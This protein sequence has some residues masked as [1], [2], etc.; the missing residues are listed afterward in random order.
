MIEHAFCGDPAES[1]DFLRWWFE[2]AAGYVE[3]RPIPNRKDDREMAFKAVKARRSFATTDFEALRDYF[4]RGYQSTD[5][6]RCGWYFGVCLRDKPVQR[7]EDGRWSGGSAEDVVA[8]LGAWADIDDHDDE[9]AERM[10]QAERALAFLSE[11]GVVPSAVVKSGGGRGRHVYFKFT[12]SVDGTTGK[13]IAAKLAK[14]LGSDPN[15]ADAAR[16]M[17][18]PGSMHTKSGRIVKVSIESWHKEAHYN[19]EAFEAA[20]DEIAHAL[21]IDV[22]RTEP[23]LTPRE[24][25]ECMGDW[26]P[27]PAEFVEEQLPTICARFKA[28]VQ[29]PNIVSEPVWHKMASLLKAMNP[30]SSLFH[31]WSE[32]YDA[33]PGKRYNWGE[34]ERK[35]RSSRPLAVRCS[36]FQELDPM[37]V[38]AACRHFQRGSSPATFVRRAYAAQ[39]G[40]PG[41][42]GAPDQPEG[43]KMDGLPTQTTEEALYANEG[44]RIAAGAEDIDPREVIV[45]E[46][47][48]WTEDL[49]DALEEQ[50]DW[51]ER[52]FT[53][54]T[55]RQWAKARKKRFVYTDEEKGKEHLL[56]RPMATAIKED[57]NLQYFFQTCY[58]YDGSIYTTPTDDG[59]DEAVIRDFILEALETLK[60]TWATWSR[61]E[62]IKRMLINNVQ[63]DKNHSVE[64]IRVH[65]VWN[66]EP[67]VPFVNGLLDMSD[68][69][70]HDWRVY[71]FSPRH[72][73][74]WKLTIPFFE[75]WYRTPKSWTLAMKDAEVDVLD[76]FRTTFPDDET[77]RSILEFLGYCL[78]RW[79]QSEECYA[80]LYGPGQNGKSTLLGM[81]AKAFGIYAVTESVQSLERNRFASASLTRAAI[82]IV[83]DMAGTGIEDTSFLKGWIGNDV[84]RAE[85]KFKASFEFKPQTKLIY[86]ANELPPTKDPTHGYFRRILLYPMMERFKRQGPGWVE[87]LRTPEAL[88]YMCYLGLL[89][90]RQMRREGRNITESK[91]MLREKDYYWRANDVVKAAIDEGIIEFGKEFS[92]PRDLLQKAMEIYAK[93]TG[94]KYPGAA[95]LLE[96]LRNYA[97]HKIEYSRPRRNGKRIHMWTGVTLGEA[98]RSLFVSR[99][100][101]DL[102]RRTLEYITLPVTDAYAKERNLDN[103]EMLESGTLPKDDSQ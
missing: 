92:V 101:V 37:S 81:L 27:V 28:Y 25:V 26:K 95:K 54:E 47:I 34:A 76:F 40:L 24:N 68:P 19:P 39:L 84:V 55:A 49:S 33:G 21:G 45:N 9:D 36:T 16:V 18:I 99:E 100:I 73:I 1:V 66:T 62:E 96:R 86:G 17:R 42:Y 97:P 74:N 67:L 53:N 71:D 87:R 46:P 83:P 56:L 78:C 77:R 32:G 38:C 72:R 52:P 7:T 59:A 3:I 90:Y 82:D 2:G 79:D 22:S 65:E 10:D 41:L 29:D 4:G 51:S 103:V 102:D 11:R 43:P 60:P 6:A 31:K 12:C 48:A 70:D 15:V 35:F 63:R 94:R 89:H 44:T 85:R 50:I 23:F 8:C 14:L 69:F 75:N 64:S 91:E 80:I 98:G 30:D 93:E 58:Y 5:M 61:A 20:I 57:F 88:S 13:R